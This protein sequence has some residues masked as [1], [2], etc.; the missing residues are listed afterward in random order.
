MNSNHYKT[1]EKFWTI[2][3]LWIIEA[4]YS[5]ENMINFY[6]IIFEQISLSQ[7]RT[8]I[9]QLSEVFNLLLKE[10]KYNYFDEILENKIPIWE[11]FENF[12]EKYNISDKWRTII[13]LM[14]AR[15]IRDSFQI[16]KN[17]SWDYSCRFCKNRNYAYKCI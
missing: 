14:I 1:F 7:S 6:K 16:F 13:T 15:E 10:K 9:L 3:W 4:S 12:I 17:E 2:V 11:T 5:S 8:S